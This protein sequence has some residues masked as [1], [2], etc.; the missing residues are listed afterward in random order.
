[1]LYDPEK[2]FKRWF[3]GGFIYNRRSGL[4]P[5]DGDPESVRDGVSGATISDVY[6]FY[7]FLIL[8]G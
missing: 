3:Y 4:V 7:I 2:V 8:F 6:R 5:L 1:M